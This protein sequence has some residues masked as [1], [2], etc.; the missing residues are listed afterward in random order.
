MDKGSITRYFIKHISQH[1]IIEINLEQYNTF[2]NDPYY[3]TVQFPWVIKGTVFSYTING[4][5]V[6]SVGEQ[7]K[8]IVEFYSKRMPGLERKI[9]NLT[10]FAIMTINTPS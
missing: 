7:N 1:N 2:K 4:R 10:Q 9:K 8:K 3:I 6:L 5:R